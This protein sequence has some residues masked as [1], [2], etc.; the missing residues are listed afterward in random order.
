MIRMSYRL[1]IF[2]FDGT[3]A[4]SFPF[5]VR[6]YNDVAREHGFREID[7]ALLPSFKGLGAREM[8]KHVGLPAWKLPF[9]AGHFI[10]LMRE[11]VAEIKPFAGVDALLA[12]LVESGVTLAVVSS[13][14]FDNVRAVLGPE[15]MQRIG[16]FECGMSIFGKAKR[17][18]R[19]LGKTATPRSQAIY[20]GDQTTD[21]EASRKVGVDFG[22]VAWGFGT[23]ESLRKLRPDRE[24]AGVAEIM[25]LAGPES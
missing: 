12:Q 17:L 4:D 24:F 22:A 1:A 19:V 20:I 8:M 9:V 7:P 21:L 14:S 10:S 6:V 16:H 3:L 18:S 2:D 5:F 23:I 11:N 15:N 25:C 13:N